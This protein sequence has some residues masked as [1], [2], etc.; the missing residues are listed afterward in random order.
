MPGS[1]SGCSSITISLS[2]IV[3]ARIA[4]AYP[5]P[6]AVE[7]QRSSNSDALDVVGLREHVDGAHLAQHP[8]GLDEFG[9]VGGE[10]GGVAGDV[11]DALGRAVD[12]PV[13]DLLRQAGARRVDDEHVRAPGALSSSGSARRASPAKNLALVMPLAR[14]P[15]I[16]S[17]TACSIS[18]MPH[19]SPAR[20]A[21]VSAIV[22]IP[23]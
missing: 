3:A 21:S 11:D 23:L 8:A 15:S 20:G 10:R 13:H 9:G 18:S 7:G 4:G 6:A 14:A 5:R 12:D 17:A 2:R 22:P 16:A 1:G 19:S